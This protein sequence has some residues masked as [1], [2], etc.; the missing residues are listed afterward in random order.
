MSLDLAQRH[1]WN[2]AR[3]LMMCVTLFKAGEGFAV[4]PTSEFDGDAD[5]IVREYD[6]FNP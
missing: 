1:A 4:V 5:L 3:T 2:L 6:P